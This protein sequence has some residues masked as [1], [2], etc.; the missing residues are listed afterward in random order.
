MV[1]LFVATATVS[2]NAVAYDGS[3]YANEAKL[4]L[5]EARAIALKAYPGTIVEEELKHEK[6]GSGL[7]FA[8]DIRAHHLTHEVAIDAKTGAVLENA[9]ETAGDDD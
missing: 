4:T 8:F 7:R 3:R 9:R 1:G 6:G 2:L 5:K